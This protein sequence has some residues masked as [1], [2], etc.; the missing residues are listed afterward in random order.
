MRQ[1][2]VGIALIVVVAGAAYIGLNADRRASLFALFQQVKREAAGYT[3]AKTPDEALQK[4]RNAI[5]DRDYD[6]AATYCANPYAEQLRKLDKAKRL[7]KSID[8]LKSAAE[9]RDI[10][11]TERTTTWLR[12]VDPFPTTFEIVDI[13]EQGD[14]ATA[15][16]TEKGIWSAPVSLKREGTGNEKSWKIH[17][18]T[19]PWLRLHV[20]RLVDKHNDFANALDKVIDQIRGK[21]IMTKGDLE[22]KLENELRDAEK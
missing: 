22:A 4:F 1:W 20:D 12:Q 21:E 19:T 15:V 11:L 3:P 13:K 7:A 16:L 9:R 14:Q 18:A 10:R 2:V 8:D 17:A 6:T 5:K